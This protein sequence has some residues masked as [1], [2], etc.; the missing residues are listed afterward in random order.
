MGTISMTIELQ[1]KHFDQGVHF[2]QVQ[3][4]SFPMATHKTHWTLI[5]QKLH[6]SSTITTSDNV[7]FMLNTS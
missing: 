2:Q 3:L 6:L 1:I 4:L 7:A 5:I